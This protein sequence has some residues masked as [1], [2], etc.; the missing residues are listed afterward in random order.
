MT[1]QNTSLRSP[2]APD[3]GVKNSGVKNSGAK[4]SEA[5]GSGAKDIGN[6][7]AA[8]GG[9]TEKAGTSTNEAENLPIMTDEKF[10]E[11]ADVSRGTIERLQLMDAVLIDW[12]S[13]HNLIARSTIDDRWRR[14]YLDSAQII[15]L[16][17]ENITHLADLGSG[18]GF[19]GLIIAA[20]LAEKDVPVTL[21]E[22]TGKKAAFLTAAAEAM[23]LTNVCVLAN[24]IE[25]VSL[26][27]RPDVVTARALA[28]LAKLSGYAHGIAA[29]NAK[30]FLPKGQYVEVELTEAAKSWQM[31]VKK[32][33]SVTSSDGVILEIEGLAPNV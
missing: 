31:S 33:P 7:G 6:D 3:S 32:H 28:N 23:K 30:Y 10:A 15:S 13:R 19:P 9:A 20:A 8:I 17:P 29:K 25:S 24:R 27:P 4:D 26:N 5:K 22:S 14:H 18:A 12:C 16:L 21:I 1:D 2:G 11:A